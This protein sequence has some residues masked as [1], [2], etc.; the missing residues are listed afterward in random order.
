M[1]LDDWRSDYAVITDEVLNLS[2]SERASGQVQTLAAK[3]AA[4]SAL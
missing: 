1:G 3:A 2:V 4:V